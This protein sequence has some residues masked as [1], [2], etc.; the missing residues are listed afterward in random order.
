[1]FKIY[2]K[3]DASP[4]IL[5]K[6]KNRLLS[7]LLILP[8]FH[9]RL[10]WNWK[11]LNSLV[12]Y[13][14]HYSPMNISL[15]NVSHYF[16]ISQCLSSTTLNRMSVSTGLVC[17]ALNRTGT[18]RK[19]AMHHFGQWSIMMPELGPDH[20][21]SALSLLPM[22]YCSCWAFLLYTVISVH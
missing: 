19:T 9:T 16:L 14:M 2:L 4:R 22:D 8:I 7:K 6:N 10:I 18:G 20:I 11:K 1:M 21:R 17:S 12:K 5:F 15:S 13:D 3:D